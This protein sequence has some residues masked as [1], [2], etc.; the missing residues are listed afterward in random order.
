MSSIGN[1]T[2][3]LIPLLSLLALVVAIPFESA[4]LFG[5]G[6]APT[7]VPLTSMDYLRAALV[8][9]PFLLAAL[10]TTSATLFWSTMT[11]LNHDGD[12]STLATIDR[13]TKYGAAAMGMLG[14]LLPAGFLGSLTALWGIALLA[15][16]FS[17]QLYPRDHSL[18]EVDLLFQRGKVLLAVICLAPL[19]T[20]YVTGR[21]QRHA[22]QNAVISFKAGSG[23]ALQGRVVRAYD[24]VTVVVSGPQMHPVLVRSSEIVR[25]DPA[26]R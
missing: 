13:R 7:A 20:G 9:I 19:V 26:P 10:I 11:T 3:Q 16:A 8:A 6:L 15:A 14:L 25:I 23:S 4:Y 17:M 1:L 2:K 5:V 18:D 21:A 24:V 12:S 22:D